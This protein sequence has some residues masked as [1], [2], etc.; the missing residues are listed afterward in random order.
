MALLKSPI[1]L[2][3][4]V[5]ALFLGCLP[6]LGLLAAHDSAQQYL[7]LLPIL[8]ALVLFAGLSS[9]LGMQ[10]YCR[11]ILKARL[12]QQPL[13]G[14]EQWLH[15][16]TFRLALRR[17]INPPRVA[18]YPSREL[19]AFALGLHRQHATIVLSEGLVHSLKPGELESVLAHEISHIANGDVQ[20]L[21]LLQGVLTIF[22][23]AP[24]RLLDD[25]VSRCWRGYSRGGRIYLWT[26]VVLQLAGGWLASLLIMRFSRECEYRAD[27]GAAQLVGIKQMQGALRCLNVMTA[28]TQHR[29][30]AAFGLS[31][32]L[33]FRF[34]QLFNS[35]P[36]L[37]ERLRALH[38]GI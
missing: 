36:A 1:L 37:H 14:L 26:L 4:T 24:A 7:L 29:Q 35:H 22:I 9:L 16:T 6:W 10:I 5:V 19:N 8:A 21:A 11:R 38:T 20:I 32:R 27:Q 15:I 18:I 33:K 34:T 25:I 3:L 30:L 31:A 17:Q 2:L 13:S 28:G 12:L 23:H